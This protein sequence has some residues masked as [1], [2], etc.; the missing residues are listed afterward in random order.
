MAKN[1]KHKGETFPAVY[2]KLT[3]KD[4]N[5]EFPEFHL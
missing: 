3:S 4:V 1:V 5:F 2:N